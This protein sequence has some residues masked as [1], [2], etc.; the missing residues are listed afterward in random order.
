MESYSRAKGRPN[1]AERLKLAIRQAKELGFDVRRIVLEDQQPGWCQ[2]GSKRIL[3][4]DLSSTTTEQLDQ[5]TQILD[6]YTAV[7]PA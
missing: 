7:A 3:F 5:I 1:V 6:S 4:L 2:V